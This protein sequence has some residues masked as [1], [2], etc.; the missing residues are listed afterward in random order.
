MIVGSLGD[1][2]FVA[3]TRTL[4]TISNYSRKVSARY[5]EHAILLNKT[6][7]EFVGPSLEEITFSI[8][9]HTM[10][11]VTPE[12]EFEQL[13]EYVEYGAV[14]DFVL[15]NTPIGIDQWVLKDA[16]MGDVLFG[17]KG[18]IIYCNVNVTLAEYINDTIIT[19][20]EVAENASQSSN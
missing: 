20:K 5:A 8:Q 12:E 1:V 17:P 3:S 10:Y 13:K 14:V 18:G 7:L 2:Y 11:G 6:K 9:L 15:N 16:E 19:T 4:R